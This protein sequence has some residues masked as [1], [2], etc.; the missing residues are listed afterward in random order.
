[1]LCFSWLEEVV[2]E[3]DER[4]AI[5]DFESETVSAFVMCLRAGERGFLAKRTSVLFAKAAVPRG[6]VLL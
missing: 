6:S 3:Q 4:I 5:D 1:M 2:D